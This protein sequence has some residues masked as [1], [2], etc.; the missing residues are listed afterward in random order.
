[1]RDCVSSLSSLRSLL[2]QRFSDAIKK[3]SLSSNP[4]IQIIPTRIVR[5]SSISGNPPE[6]VVKAFSIKYQK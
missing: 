4:T 6:E 3:A 1:M 5:A 2:C